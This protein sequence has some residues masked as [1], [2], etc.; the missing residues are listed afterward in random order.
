MLIMAS[1]DNLTPRRFAPAFPNVEANR[2]LL[3][4]VK[5]HHPEFYPG[6]ALSSQPACDG[7][8]VHYTG[9]YYACCVVAGNIWHPMEGRDSTKYEEY[10]HPFLSTSR[11]PSD[12]EARLTIPDDEIIRPAPIGKAYFFPVPSNTNH[13]RY[14]IVP[15]FDHRIPPDGVKIKIPAPWLSLDPLHDDPNSNNSYRSYRECF[16]TLASSSPQRPSPQDLICCLTKEYLSVDFCRVIPKSEERWF[17]GND[18]QKYS[19]SNDQHNGPLNR[20]CNVMPFRLDALGYFGQGH[21]S[22]V[23][24]LDK[25]TGLYTLPT[26]AVRYP[27]ELLNPRGRLQFHDIFHNYLLYPHPIKWIPVEYLFTRFAWT[28]FSDQVMTLLNDAKGVTFP[29]AP[30]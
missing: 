29:P 5:V 3:D 15:S 11:D 22:L 30:S 28:L 1:V 26:H 14:A 27:K 16:A 7:G 18:M 6:G 23:P 8:G 25:S 12:R 19:T 4:Y 10:D 17:I 13:R 2:Y 24:K 20:I 9:L 21:L